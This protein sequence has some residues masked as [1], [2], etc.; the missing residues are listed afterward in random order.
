M[1]V[2]TILNEIINSDLSLDALATIKG[3]VEFLIEK[4][5]GCL[6]SKETLAK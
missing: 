3:T 4:K 6:G 2:S 1:K 5:K